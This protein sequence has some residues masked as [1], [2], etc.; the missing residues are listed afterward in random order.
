MISIR[1]RASEYFRFPMPDLRPILICD[2]PV[3]NQ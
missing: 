1:H 3:L 2:F